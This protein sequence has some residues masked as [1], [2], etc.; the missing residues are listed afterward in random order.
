M[1]DFNP[2]RI[3]RFESP[4][5]PWPPDPDFDTLPPYSESGSTSPA[6]RL[7]YEITL[8]RAPFLMDPFLEPW[9]YAFKD[10]DAVLASTKMPFLRTRLF[11][12]SWHG[13]WL[14]MDMDSERVL[15]VKVR[16]YLCYTLR[17]AI[18]TADPD[19]SCYSRHASVRVGRRSRIRRTF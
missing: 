17:R 6:P 11:E 4:S 18:E 13:D 10:W 14:E 12:T 16:Q 3:R 1:F 2:D 7:P 9:K 8:V 19:G 15:V 5:A